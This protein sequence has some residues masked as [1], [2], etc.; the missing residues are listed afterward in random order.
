VSGG[1]HKGWFESTYSACR[2]AIKPKSIVQTSGSP[3]IPHYK[4]DMLPSFLLS[5]AL[6]LSS[7]SARAVAPVT[8]QS[9]ASPTLVRRAAIPT[10]TLG[11]KEQYA[12]AQV[13]TVL[14][15]LYPEL[16]CLDSLLLPSYPERLFKSFRLGSTMTFRR[17]VSP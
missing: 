3:I 9:S 14:C 8:T 7:V 12:P 1:Y 15:S 2:R 4:I 10:L 5:L 17:M 11:P 16:I 13:C 6:C